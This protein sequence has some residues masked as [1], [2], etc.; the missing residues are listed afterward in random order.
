[1]PTKSSVLRFYDCMK[2]VHVAGRFYEDRQYVHLRF[3]L[4]VTLE[5]LIIL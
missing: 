5:E 1:M 3:W 2:L 4:F